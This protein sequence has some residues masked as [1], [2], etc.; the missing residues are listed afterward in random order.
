MLINLLIYD[1]ILN[2]FDIINK[3]KISSD[4][5]RAT[6]IIL[7]FMAYSKVR[8]QLIEHFSIYKK[9]HSN[10]VNEYYLF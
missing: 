5:S 3:F 8:S 9:N 2:L 1:K 7:T 4:M 6:H 10:S